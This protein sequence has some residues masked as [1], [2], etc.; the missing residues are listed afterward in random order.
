[1]VVLAATN[2]PSSLD[3]ALTRPG[4][5][6]RIITI[7]YPNLLGRLAIIKVHCRD[8]VMAADVNYH[9]VARATASFSG[10]DIMNLINLAAIEAARE[11]RPS[12]PSHARP[13]ATA[14]SLLSSAQ[15]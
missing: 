5:F 8:K 15:C 10:A 2:R 9:R 3:S 1:V 4:R 11:V 6:D 14:A 7:P 12:H 13:A